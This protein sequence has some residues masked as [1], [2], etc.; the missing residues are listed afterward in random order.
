MPTRI[1]DGLREQIRAAWSQGAT[2]KDIAQ[3]FGVTQGSVSKLVAGIPKPVPAIHIRRCV[4][5]KRPVRYKRRCED[6]NRIW[7]QTYNQSR[8]LRIQQ[9]DPLLEG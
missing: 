4:D 2:Q 6:C 3:Q 8:Y 1:N 9:L 7:R 5:C